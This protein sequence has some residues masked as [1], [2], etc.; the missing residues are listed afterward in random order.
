MIKCI[1]FIVIYKIDTF[2]V[3][4]YKINIVT[5]QQLKY[6]IALDNYKNFSVAAEKCFVNQST[7]TIQVKKLEDEMGLQLFDRSQSPFTVTLNGQKIIEKARM[8]MREVSELKE[9]VGDE[10]E[11]L[12]G[13]FTIGII[14]TL[15]PYI[16]PDF[17]GGFVKNNPETI[18]AVKEMESIEIISGLKNGKI[19][20]GILV[21]P[22]N[23][24]DLREI[25]M[26]NEP[27]VFFGGPNQPFKKEEIISSKSMGDLENLWL[28]K[29]GHCLKNQV[30]NICEKSAVPRSI[31]FES[32]SIETL[33]NMVKKYGGFTLIPE[34]SI[35][36]LD[37]GNINHFKEPKPTREVS[38]VVHSNFAKENLLDTI[39]KEILNIIPIEF[40][41]NQR[42]IRV[43]WR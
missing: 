8:I 25:K 42:Y 19:D 30:L 9:M 23:D 7:I 33:K 27:F 43:K 39:R 20:I 26:Y 4:I 17:S 15:S 5:I 6:I 34:M 16:I 31:E 41:K 18:L 3:I 36:E 2:V 21:T 11:G 1:G 29:E 37:E 24:K 28:L 35:N 14:P 13:R 22:L 40:A 12:K 32:G 38:L 10:K